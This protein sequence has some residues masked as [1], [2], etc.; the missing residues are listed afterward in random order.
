MVLLL[1]GFSH[2]GGL[3]M[4][5]LKSTI[6][7]AVLALAVGSVEGAPKGGSKGS[8]APVKTASVK[9]PKITKTTGAPKSTAPKGG[10]KTTVSKGGP[11]TTTATTK[12]PKA[13]AQLARAEARAAKSKKTDLASDTLTGTSSTSFSGASTGDVDFTTGK[14][15]ER[16][17]KNT[18]LRSKLETQLLALGYEG[19]VY[20]A[21]Y[22]FKNLGQFVAAVNNAQNHTLSFEQLKIQM[23]GLSVDADGVVLRANLNPDGTVTMVPLDEVTNPAPTQSLGQAKKTLAAETTETP[24]TLTSI[25]GR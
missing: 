20:Q 10:P 13:D 25:S 6:C 16:L 4:Y 19:S 23:T 8:A 24:E 12:G 22:G 17:S 1:L 2:V 3:D 14:V 21:G 15:G 11:K 18:A 9:G 5:L 7:V